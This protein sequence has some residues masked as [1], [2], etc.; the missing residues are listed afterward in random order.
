MIKHTDSSLKSFLLFA[1]CA[2]GGRLITAPTPFHHMQQI[3]APGYGSFYN[4]YEINYATDNE[5]RHPYRLEHIPPYS[6]F[7]AKQIEG[8][9]YMAVEWWQIPDSG[10]GNDGLPMSS[11]YS[12][13]CQVLTVLFRLT[14]IYLRV[15]S[16]FEMNGDM[17]VG[18]SNDF[19]YL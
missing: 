11:F 13:K 10:L 4:R 15:I 7:I 9:L 6:V 3:L 16:G 17:I 18:S 1:P 8:S 12:I 2:E 14:N 5:S 19:R